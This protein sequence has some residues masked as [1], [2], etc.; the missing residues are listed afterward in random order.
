M[1]ILPDKAHL[2]E[3]PGIGAEAAGV[4]AHFF[5]A[6]D[7]LGI[8]K[9]SDRL[10]LPVVA[11]AVAAV[12]DSLNAFEVDRPDDGN[13]DNRPVPSVDRLL[14]AHKIC[15]NPGA[16]IKPY[17]DDDRL[18]HQRVSPADSQISRAGSARVGIGPFLTAG[19]EAVAALSWVYV[20]CAVDLPPAVAVGAVIKIDACLICIALNR[21]VLPEKRRQWQWRFVLRKP[22]RGAALCLQQAMPVTSR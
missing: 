8:G 9:C 11:V 2:A 4:V 21:L 6:G 12:E 5:Y 13:A 14:K 7:K 19:E 15:L 3:S 10:A 1:Q 17:L 16:G 18:A 22:F 20:A